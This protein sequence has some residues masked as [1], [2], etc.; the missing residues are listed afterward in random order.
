[1]ILEPRK[2]EEKSL[3]VRMLV[4]MISVWEIMTGRVLMRKVIVMII[5]III[6]MIINIVLLIFT[7][8]MVITA[9]LSRYFP[10]LRAVGGG[11]ERR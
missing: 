1:M 9:L 8:M 2:D 7:A 11:T 6:I 5:M 4:R 10:G 3:I